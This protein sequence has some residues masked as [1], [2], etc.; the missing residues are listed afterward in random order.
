MLQD[1]KYEPIKSTK[2]Q[3]V[4]CSLSLA[5]P[6][7][8]INSRWALCLLGRHVVHYCAPFWA[9]CSLAALHSTPGCFLLALPVLAW[10]RGCL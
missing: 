2:V 4:D 8:S 3:F 10:S 5:C 9:G 1:V 6:C 7:N